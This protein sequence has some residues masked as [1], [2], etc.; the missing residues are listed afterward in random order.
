MQVEER[1]A[2]GY[3]NGVEN[4]YGYGFLAYPKPHGIAGFPWTGEGFSLVTA[5]ASASNVLPE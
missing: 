4:G 5:I 3:G 1:S 2:C